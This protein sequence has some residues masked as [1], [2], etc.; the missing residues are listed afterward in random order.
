MLLDSLGGEPG[1]GDMNKAGSNELGVLVRQQELYQE[2]L[3]ELDIVTSTSHLIF[4]RGIG[5]KRLPS[6]SKSCCTKTS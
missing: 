1:R 3:A 5:N 4:R 6:V 2:R